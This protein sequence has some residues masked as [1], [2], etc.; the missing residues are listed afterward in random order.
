MSQNKVRI[1]DAERVELARERQ[2]EE[3][4]PEGKILDG[5]QPFYF[6]A[7]SRLVS[8]QAQATVPKDEELKKK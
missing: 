6:L 8:R 4:C 3:Y 7:T 5:R 2:V 1:P